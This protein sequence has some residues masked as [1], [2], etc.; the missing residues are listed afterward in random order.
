MKPR[1]TPARL[2]I[3]GNNGSNASVA[4]RLE[5]KEDA[6]GWRGSVQTLEPVLSEGATHQ[7]RLGDYR[8]GTIRLHD[9]ARNGKTARFTGV[10]SPQRM[11]KATATS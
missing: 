7:V 5:Y 3:E 6:S 8:S 11:T 4:V 1:K 2:L 9:V 10:G